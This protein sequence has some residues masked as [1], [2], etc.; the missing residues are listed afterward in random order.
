MDRRILA[1]LEGECVEIEHNDEAEKWLR[2]NHY[3]IVGDE[4]RG[5]FDQAAFDEIIEVTT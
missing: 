4:E 5:T 1:L 3:C 2:G